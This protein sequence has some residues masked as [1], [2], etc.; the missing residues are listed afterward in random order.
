MVKFIPKIVV[1]AVIR[2]AVSRSIEDLDQA[3]ACHG[4]RDL[5]AGA[6]ILDLIRSPRVPSA[7]AL[8][9]IL[10]CRPSVTASICTWL[11]RLTSLARSSSPACNV[12][13]PPTAR[14]LR[15]PITSSTR[16]KQGLMQ[17]RGI[18]LAQCHVVCPHRLSTQQRA[19][20]HH[21]G[22]EQ[23]QVYRHVDLPW[24]AAFAAHAD[25][26]A[27]AV[28]AVWRVIWSPIPDHT[29]PA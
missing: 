8:P 20:I 25:H 4:T 2:R 15:R 7:N 11:P 17:C 14:L 19:G 10:T 1:S 22:V 16:V 21:H 12:V 26:A 3:R 23:R 18:D 28:E 24:L 9:R 13:P 29:V 27:A 5:A 6:Q